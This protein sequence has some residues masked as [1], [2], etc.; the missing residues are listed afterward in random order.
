MFLFF[1]RQHMSSGCH[2]IIEKQGAASSPTDPYAAFGTPGY[3]VV[4][5][6]NHTVSWGA[7]PSPTPSYSENAANTPSPSAPTNANSWAA[8]ADAQRAPPTPVHPTAAVTAQ[9]TPTSTS[10]YYQDVRG[11]RQGPVD[12]MVRARVFVFESSSNWG[13][14]F[15]F[16]FCLVF[17]GS[18]GSLS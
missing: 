2:R 10:W 13:K 7:F 12:E 8:S 17:P 6:S 5:Q 3:G 15:S 14:R 9:A 18:Q 4:A 11:N 1:D 16:D